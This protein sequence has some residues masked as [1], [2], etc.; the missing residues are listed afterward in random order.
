MSL[1]SR[2]VKKINKI[3]HLD[4]LLLGRKVTKIKYNRS[5]KPSSGRKVEKFKI[6]Q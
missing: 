4:P 3:D 1:K 6:N 2:K 5:F